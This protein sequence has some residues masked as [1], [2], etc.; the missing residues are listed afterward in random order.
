[1]KGRI[2]I[3]DDEEIVIR[4]CK[5]ILAGRDFQ[6][7]AA[8]N[9]LEALA[10][11]QEDDYDMLILD[12]K[13]PKMNGIEVLQ[14]VKEAHP[15]IDVIMITGLNQIDTAVKAMKLGAFDYLPKPF[16]PEELEIVVARAFERRQLLQENV[17][18]KN[19]VTRVDSWGI[20]E[21]SVP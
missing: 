7:D 6:V 18:L 11:I 5:R 10:K 2:L 13:M 12:I 19:E 20:E 9:G 4:S 14:Q 17:N 3:V 1:M 15:D 16:D 8:S 21:T